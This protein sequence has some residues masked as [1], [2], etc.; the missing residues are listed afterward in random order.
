MHS[1]QNF[2]DP[3]GSLTF[4][5]RSSA[6]SPRRRRDRE[7]DQGPPPRSLW[8]SSSRAFSGRLHRIQTTFRAFLP[9][10]FPI[11]PT[12]S[13][14]IIRRLLWLGTALEWPATGSVEQV[15]TISI[16]WHNPFKPKPEQIQMLNIDCSSQRTRVKLPAP[17]LLLLHNTDNFT[18]T[19]LIRDTGA[20]KEI[21]ER[22]VSCW[23]LKPGCGFEMICFG[24]T[25][26]SDF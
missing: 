10:Y 11:L 19:V 4:S 20:T 25:S 22:G 24:S 17:M 7:Q 12:V 2:P 1:I 23:Q 6:W 16:L 9:Q 14:Y 13:V 18:N 21:L 15:I 3:T 26:G 8:R 5:R